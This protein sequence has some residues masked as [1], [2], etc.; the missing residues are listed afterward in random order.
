MNCID[1]KKKIK[2]FII[3]NFLL[4]DSSNNLNDEDSF[5]EKGI[6][7]S[8]G[9]LELVSFVEKSFN[10][11]FEDEEL[12]PDNLDSINKVSDF[13]LKKTST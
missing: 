10:V 3:E 12:I 1:I 4:G 6:I 7:D 2:V 13:I 11:K 9:V 8:T 5:F